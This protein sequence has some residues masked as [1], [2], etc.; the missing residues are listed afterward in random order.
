MAGRRPQAHLERR[1]PL[2]QQRL[3]ARRREFVPESLLAAAIQREAAERKLA[4][5]KK[6]GRINAARRAPRKKV[7]TGKPGGRKPRG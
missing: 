3:D 2:L 7:A 4:A 6:G 1:E 5:K